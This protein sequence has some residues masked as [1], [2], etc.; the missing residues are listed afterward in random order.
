MPGDSTRG[1]TLFVYLQGKIIPAVEARIS[2]WAGGFVYGDGIYTTL[3][4]YQ[5]RA[6]DLA[7]HHRRLIIQAEEIDLPLK[8]GQEDLAASI[9]ELV[10]RNGFQDR[11]GRMRITVTRGGTFDHPVPV[12]GFETLEPTVLITLANINPDLPR[13]QAEGIAT[14]CLDPAFSRG[15]FP[16]LKT[17]NALPGLRALRQ[18]MKSGC[19]EAILTGPKGELL[20]GA[21]SNLF[22]VQGGALATPAVGAGFLAGRTRERVLGIAAQKGI[23]AAERDLKTADLSTADE[24]FVASSVREILPVVLV[25]AV[26]VGQGK[27]GPVTRAIQEGYRTL[28]ARALEID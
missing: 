19:Q 11:D 28:I 7:A 8:L 27:P 5:G 24:I 23:D 22:L 26:K 10:S 15:N 3:R 13:W 21:V 9:E 6:L 2:V 1:N 4:L 12:T 18:A 14:V 17:L 25:D 20:E 16:E